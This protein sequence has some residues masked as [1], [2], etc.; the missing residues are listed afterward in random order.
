M[1]YGFIFA[2]VQMYR[3]DDDLL[4]GRDVGASKE[5]IRLKSVLSARSTSQKGKTTYES[6]V[7]AE[8]I[9]IWKTA[10]ASVSR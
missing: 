4:P 5:V 3:L 8:L 6:S 9:L 10:S 1:A 7:L 2:T